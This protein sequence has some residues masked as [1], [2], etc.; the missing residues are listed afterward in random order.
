MQCLFYTQRDH[1]KTSS[2][3]YKR[4]NARAHTHTH[5]RARARIATTATAKVYQVTFNYFRF[6]VTLRTELLLAC[7]GGRY[8]PLWPV[9]GAR[10]EQCLASHECT[11]T[12]FFEHALCHAGRC[13][14]V[15][16]TDV[17]SMH[18]VFLNFPGS[19]IIGWRSGSWWRAVR[20]CTLCGTAQEHVKTTRQCRARMAVMFRDCN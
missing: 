2:F 16:D 20:C 12:Q 18:N 13:A 14:I 7:F 6:V 3:I 5:T 10:I 11:R 4:Q 9:S 15:A 17:E 1:V 19:V 8:D